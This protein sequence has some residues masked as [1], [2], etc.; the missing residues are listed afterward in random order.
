MISPFNKISIG[1]YSYTRDRGYA[2]E[3]EMVANTGG[4]LDKNLGY[5]RQREKDGYIPQLIIN[6]TIVNDGRKIMFSAQPVGYLTQPEYSLGEAAPPIDAV[7]FAAFFAN[8]DPYNLRI[9]SALRMNATFPL[10]LPVVKMPSQ[11]IMNIMDAGLSDNFGAET[12]ARYL[13]VMRH[14]I[15]DNTGGAV[16]LDIRDTRENSVVSNSDQSTLGTQ[17]FDPLF[18]IQNKWEAFQ[19]YSFGFIKD[20]CPS[21]MDSKLRFITLQ[22]VPLESKK[23]AALN[24]H[25][26]Q[27]EKEDLFQ[28]IYNPENQA[29]IDTFLQLVKTK[30]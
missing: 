12:A 22:Y 19:S 6:G 27:K 3:Q 29:A 17:L 5:F 24:F 2:M 23:V 25:L 4:L 13:Y 9:T 8:Q 15:Q 7:D 14:W 11:P 20:Y 16:I 28:S 18:T 1:G 21:F 26:T 30:I 10:V